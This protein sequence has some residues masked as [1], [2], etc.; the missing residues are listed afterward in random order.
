MWVW[1]EFN[2]SSDLQDPGY[3]HRCQAANLETFLL[4][5]NCFSSPSFTR[6][7]QCEFYILFVQEH[8][9]PSQAAGAD[10]ISCAVPDPGSQR[11]GVVLKSRDFFL[12]TW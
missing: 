1:G 6:C 2:N 9:L 7:F 4:L 3:L 10:I 8:L 5:R 11:P 12:V